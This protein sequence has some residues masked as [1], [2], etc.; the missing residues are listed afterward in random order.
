MDPLEVL[1]CRDPVRLL[2]L[3]AATE[4]AAELAE[5]RDDNLSIRIANQVGRMLSGK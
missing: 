2:A 5:L 3:H 1:D 4:K